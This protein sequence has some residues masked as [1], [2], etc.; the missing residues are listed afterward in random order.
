MAKLIH[1]E[2]ATMKDKLKRLPIFGPLGAAIVRIVRATSRKIRHARP[3]FR[4]IDP[5][6]SPDRA[7][8]Q[9][10]NLLEYTKTSASS[11]SGEAF[12]AGY[13][14]LEIGSLHLVC[15]L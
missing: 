6:A 9:I 11:Y 3:A 15:L 10:F 1:Y 14:T 8:W 5:G 13:H 12:P 4:R 7:V 2:A